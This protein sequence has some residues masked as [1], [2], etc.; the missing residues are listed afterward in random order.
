MREDIKAVGKIR[1]TSDQLVKAESR[2]D[3]EYDR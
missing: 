1:K 3:R 2:R